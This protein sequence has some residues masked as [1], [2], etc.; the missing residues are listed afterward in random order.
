MGR[1]R[2]QLPDATIGERRRVDDDVARRGRRTMATE[3]RELDGTVTE[4]YD[5]TVD[6]DR[7]ERLMTEVF[8]EHRAAGARRRLTGCGKGTSGQ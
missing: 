7:I 1:E 8:T 5:V 4:Y 6:G 2:A 3:A